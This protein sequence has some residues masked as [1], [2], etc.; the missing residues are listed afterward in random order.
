[1]T[2]QGPVQI[3][4]PVYNEGENVVRLHESLVAG[5]VP[6]D[7]L[8]FVYDRDDD[9]SLPYVE[10]IAADDGRVQA[11]RNGFGPGVVNALRWGFSRCA[12]GPVVVAM[13][14]NSDDLSIVP[15]M[16]HMWSEGATIVTPSRYMPGGEQQGGGRLK[17]ALS[18]LAGTSLH[19]LG[20]PTA[21]PT[22]NYKLYD[23]AWLRRQEVE[24]RGF[25]VALELTCKAFAAG[26]RIEQLPTCWSDRTSGESRFQLRRLLPRYLR[27]Y[28]LILAVLLRR[29]AG[30]AR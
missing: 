1:M 10:K 11:E 29:A 7:T 21:D 13:G 14:D 26:E 5:R 3:I 20:L 24:S 22:N 27:W 17:S 23:G 4:V 28:G 9:T 18:R 30:G 8:A 19:R 16:V 2:R 12:P 15:Q 25:E 6:Y